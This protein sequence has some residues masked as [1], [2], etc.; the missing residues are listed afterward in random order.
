MLNKFGGPDAKANRFDHAIDALKVVY[1]KI[2]DNTYVSFLP[3]YQKRNERATL[4]SAPESISSTLWNKNVHPRQFLDAVTSVY[5]DAQDE[6]KS[7]FYG[8]SPIAKALVNAKDKGFP[9]GYKGPKLII[10]LSD[11]EDTSTPEYEPTLRTFLN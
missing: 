3:F 2:P 4:D 11:G 9:R 10:V 8:F 1:S 5:L 7:K 6:V